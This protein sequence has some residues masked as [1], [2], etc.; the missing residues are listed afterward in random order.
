MVHISNEREL[1]SAVDE[2]LPSPP[3]YFD[4]IAQQMVI[5]LTIKVPVKES[6][7]D[8]DNDD[9]D[10]D[11]EVDNNDFDYDDNDFDDDNE[12]H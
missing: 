5:F 10:D 9:F 11:K 12:N 7:Y 6:T 2:T 4:D 3:A 8:N 1:R